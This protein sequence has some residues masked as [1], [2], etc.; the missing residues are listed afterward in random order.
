MLLEIVKFV[1]QCCCAGRPEPVPVEIIEREASVIDYLYLRDRV[2][3]GRLYTGDKIPVGGDPDHYL[4]LGAL[5][6]KYPEARIT[7]YRKNKIPQFMFAMGEF[8]EEFLHN[9]DIY[10]SK[11]LLRDFLVQ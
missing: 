4:L 7:Q 11:V 1:W 3:S 8:S 9:L 10:L 2:R 6:S 5:A